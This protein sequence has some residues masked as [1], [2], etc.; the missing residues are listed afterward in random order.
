MICPNLDLFVNLIVSWA[1]SRVRGQLGGGGP[2]FDELTI[3]FCTVKFTS[4][5][6]HNEILNASLAPGLPVD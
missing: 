1:D 6:L 2:G 5:V 3:I 4:R